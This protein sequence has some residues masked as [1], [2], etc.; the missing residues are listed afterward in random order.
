MTATTRLLYYI[1]YSDLWSGC[2]PAPIS[3]SNDRHVNSHQRA[4]FILILVITAKQT[5]TKYL[6]VTHGADVILPLPVKERGLQHKIHSSMKAVDC[7]WIRPGCVRVFCS[8]D[9]GGSFSRQ[10]NLARNRSSS[11]GA[12]RLAGVYRLLIVLASVTTCVRR[13]APPDAKRKRQTPVTPVTGHCFP[14]TQASFCSLSLPL[15]LPLCL[16]LSCCSFAAKSRR[17]ADRFRGR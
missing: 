5:V 15:P 3:S 2:Q 9:Q 1:R 14:P 16:M 17:S 6:C 7:A 11:P 10:L 8:V 4:D 13:P 12:V